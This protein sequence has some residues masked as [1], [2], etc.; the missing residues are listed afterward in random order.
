M[1][2]DDAEA[3]GPDRRLHNGREYGRV[4]YRQ[5]KA[6]GRDVVVLVAPRPK[7]APRRGRLG[8]MVSTKVAKRAVR[9]HQLKRWVREY[10][11]RELKAIAHGWDVVVLFRRDPSGDD[12][13]SKLDAEL[14]RLVPKAL[15][16][17]AKPGEGRGPRKGANAAE[18]WPS[19]AIEESRSCLS[20]RLLATTVSSPAASAPG[21]SAVLVVGAGG[22]G[23]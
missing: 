5:Q 1:V 7:R 11:R 17:E 3:F 23:F 4:F 8:I 20:P 10:F 9:R 19:A 13:H 15:A 2:I 22:V 18:V 12:A 6:A 16:A 14:R 21:L